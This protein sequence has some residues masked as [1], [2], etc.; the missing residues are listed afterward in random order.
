MAMEMRSMDKSPIQKNHEN[1]YEAVINHPN[2]TWDKLV[3]ETLTLSGLSVFDRLD[4]PDFKLPK[5]STA[6][7]LGHKTLRKF[8]CSRVDDYGMSIPWDNWVESVMAFRINKEIGA[9]AGDAETL[10]RDYD[11]VVEELGRKPSSATDFSRALSYVKAQSVERAKTKSKNHLSVLSSRVNNLLVDIDYEKA[12]SNQHKEKVGVLHGKMTAMEENHIKMLSDQENRLNLDAEEKIKALKIESEAEKQV[13][14]DESRGAIEILKKAHASEMLALRQEY[15][16]RIE[17]LKTSYEDK[18]QKA[19]DDFNLRINALTQEI[20]SLTEK[21]ETGN[22]IEL[23]RYEELKAENARYADR[24]EKFEAQIIA[25]KIDLA[26]YTEK[27]AEYEEEKKQ[28]NVLIGQLKS[29]IKSYELKIQKTINEKDHQKGLLQDKLTILK[30][31][32]SGALKLQHEKH[33]KE[34]AAIHL[35]LSE[36]NDK[37]QKQSG[38]NQAQAT[39]FEQVLEIKNH[40]EGLLKGELKNLE[41]AHI[42]ALEAQDEKHKQEVAAINLIL[43]EESA[44]HE[45]GIG[46]MKCEIEQINQNHAEINKAQKSKFA[47]VLESIQG[48]DVSHNLDVAKIHMDYSEKENMRK[49]KLDQQFSLKAKE[50]ADDIAS[51]REDGQKIIDSLIKSNKEQESIHEK[52]MLNRGTFGKEALI[53][54][55]QERVKQYADFEI[56][57]KSISDDYEQRLT[58]KESRFKHYEDK[59]KQM[60]ARIDHS[61]VQRIQ[62]LE[63]KLQTYYGYLDTAKTKYDQ[64]VFKHRVLTNSQFEMTEVVD[65]LTI[66]KG[67][68][69]RKVSKQNKTIRG[70]ERIIRKYKTQAMAAISVGVIVS[71]ANW[72][73]I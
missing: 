66:L 51:T 46:Q 25:L 27:V 57:L 43:S 14:R 31:A 19:S 33:N 2:L 65:D 22:Y 6:S 45:Y 55:E 23:P 42:N 70:F 7:I 59:I 39:N 13:I 52:N 56:N 53:R 68:L 5:T 12:A 72:L 4:S 9:T 54:M 28:N 3:Q 71:L 38:V 32:H 47:Q 34:V 41:A 67:K 24:I 64:L 49:V 48:K 58:A 11:M 20:S 60:E 36:E 50:H 44:K 30:A 1:K 8:V 21:Y 35:V 61:S 16:G 69:E 62:L 63:S 37:N 26:S 40:Q 73:T 17:A 10:I 15:E 18:I 29:D